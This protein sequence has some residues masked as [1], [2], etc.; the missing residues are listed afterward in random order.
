MSTPTHEELLQF[1]HYKKAQSRL[2]VGYEEIQ[3]RLT[4]DQDIIHDCETIAADYLQWDV[5]WKRALQENHRILIL[6]TFRLAN[7]K[8]EIEY[9]LKIIDEAL[10]A[11]TE[12]T[13]DSDAQPSSDEQNT[14]TEE[15]KASSEESIDVGTLP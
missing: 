10:K 2:A 8:S 12:E 1:Y 7:A 9:L 5:N 6:H 13:K 14:T 3:T 11:T 15:T 4:A